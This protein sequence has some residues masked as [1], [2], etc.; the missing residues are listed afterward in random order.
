[1]LDCI[2]DRPLPP[3]CPVLYLPGID[4]TGRLLFKQTGLQQRHEL[5][6]LSYPQDDRHT[7]ADLTSLAA[8]HL[9][10]TGPAVVVAESFGG[11]VALQLALARPELVRR[12]VLV[13]TFAY[14]PRRLFIEM[15]AFAGP[16]LPHRPAH[17]MTRSVRSAFFFGRGV[18]RADRDAWWDRTADVS[19]HVYGHRFR[20]LAALDLRARL[21]EI[22]VPA[23][24]IGSPN[25][26]I[27]P[28]SASRLLAARLPRSR[29]LVLRAGHAALIDPRV[30]VAAWLADEELWPR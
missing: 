19:Q 7:Y 3:Q 30:D 17:P 14:Y 18:P 13:S 26:W 12:L 20:L 8:R 28:F 4:G 9:G 11:G 1:M 29:L 2:H 15:L 6:C 22:A 27:V 25:D 5:R 21:A 24:V 10:E 16:W 23:L